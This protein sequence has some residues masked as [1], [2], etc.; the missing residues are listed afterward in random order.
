MS[1]RSQHI[2]GILD[3]YRN[4][5]LRWN[6]QINLISRQDAADRLDGLIHQCRNGWDRLSASGSC[7]L[8]EASRL[9]YFDLG[10]GAGLPGFVWH[11]QMV[12]AGLPARTLLVEP[13]QKRAWFLE[14]AAHLVSPGQLQVLANRWGEIGKDDLSGIVSEP[15]PSHI[16]ISLK[17]LRLPDSSV[18]EGLVPFLELAESCAIGEGLEITLLIVR[19]YPPDQEW[20][21]DLA[22]VLDIP[23]SRCPRS[24]LSRLFRG[25]GGRILKPTDRTGAS[26]VLSE[27]RI[28]IS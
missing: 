9:W 15:P 4:L 10:S 20:S 21:E 24:V 26:L 12:A 8:M 19:F 14:R 1:R 2:D 11:N 6:N 17:A 22:G 13:R 7:G 16:V 27:Y 28:Q 18:L 25:A 3:D 23:P 5:I